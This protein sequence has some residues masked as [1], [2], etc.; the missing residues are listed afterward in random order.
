MQWG[1]RPL[2]PEESFTECCR[3]A[4]RLLRARN[5][6]HEFGV[7]L[8]FGVSRGTS[9]AC[10]YRALTKE[11]LRDVR[12][13]G[14]DSF[15]GLPP[16]AREQ[17]WS[18][19][20]FWSTRGATEEYLRNRGLDLRRVSLVEGWFKDT[21][22]ELTRRRL[23]ITRTSLIM[24]DCDIESATRQALRFC[25]PS[26][27]DSAVIF[28]D[29]WNSQSAKK[30]PGER[31]AFDSF[32]R[33]FPDFAVQPVATYAS[34]ARVFLVTRRPAQRRGPLVHLPVRHAR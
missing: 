20:A 9:L 1:W 5:P 26:I 13:I 14:F 8:E 30:N 4:I 6:H 22:T 34:N 29:D 32:L 24:I 18:P 25:E 23:D 17:G 15:Q 2:V 31:E 21:L 33:E 10:M 28:F 3:D 27:G 7:Y 16:E 12:L 11:G 19:G